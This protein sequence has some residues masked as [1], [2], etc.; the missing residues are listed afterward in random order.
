[1]R[2]GTELQEK[3]KS[4]SRAQSQSSL[5][6]LRDDK[7]EK[8]PTRRGSSRARSKRDGSKASIFYKCCHPKRRAQRGVE[9]P[10]Y[11]R[12]GVGCIGVFR[13]GRPNHPYE[14]KTGTRRGPR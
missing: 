14:C 10:L 8:R 3:S 12:R 9:G 5:A 6:L 13:L 7:N 11:D 1:M 4:L 2:N